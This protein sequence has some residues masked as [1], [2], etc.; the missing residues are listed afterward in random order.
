MKPQCIQAVQAAAA[1][2]GHAKGLSAAQLADI[3][4]RMQR[5]LRHLA[6]T[7]PD[8]QTKP[9]AQRYAEAAAQ[10]MQE[11]KAEAALK[12]QRA[13]MQVVARGATDG[14]IAS[15]LTQYKGLS[16]SEALGRDMSNVDAGISGLRARTMS[17][18]VGLVDAVRNADG[19]SFGRR[20]AMFLWDAENPQ[21]TSDLAREIYASADGST[22]NKI[23]QEGAKAWLQVID[24]MRQRFNAAGGD[25]G[26]L[27]YGYAPIS[28]EFR[29]VR[30]D[31]DLASRDRWVAKTLGL[32]DRGRYVD[33]TG[34]KLGDVAVTDMLNGVWETI[35]S[36]GLNKQ[37]PGQFKG[38]GARA[39]AG[40]EARVLHFK[41]GGA[42]LDYMTSYGR[43]SMYDL[44]M[45]H[46]GKM[47]RDIGLVEAYGP[48]P[49]AQMRTQFDLARQADGGELKKFGFGVGIARIDAQGMW[50]TLSGAASTPASEVGAAFFRHVRNVQSLKLAGTFL[51]MFPDLATYFVTTGFNKLG[52]WNGLANLGR[53]AL[54]ANRDWAAMHGLMADSMARELNRFMGENIGQGWSARL[55]NSQ[56]KLTLGELWT[57]T[58]DRAFGLTKMAALARQAGKDWGSLDQYDRAL[59]ERGGVTA[60]DWRV[61][62]SAQLDSLNGQA[63]LTPDAI[64]AVNHPSAAQVADKI[65]GIVKNQGADAVIKP[66]LEVRTIQTWNGTQAGTA[67]GE[68]ARSVM[69]FK[70]FPIAMVTRHWRQMM[71]AP[72]V[73]DGSAPML[74][75]PW[76]YGGGLAV[77]A[78]ILGAISTQATA[79]ASGKDPIDVTG[80]HA[81]KFW[82]QAFATGGAGGFYADLLTRDSSQDRSAN[83][84]IGKLFG[85]SISD[86][87]TVMQITKGNIDDKLAG[88]QTH[89]AAQG[90]QFAR[91]HVPYLNVWY[92]KAAI[93]HAGMNALQENVSPGYLGRMRENAARQWGEDYW[94]APGTGGPQ[95]APDLGQA[96]GQ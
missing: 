16:R 75:N 64:A 18:L 40:S 61:V 28:H 62:R 83:D 11:V 8:W 89:A 10:A 70:S 90:L 52:Y 9:T 54:K 25:V 43:G 32:L 76:L 78:T 50:R 94:W 93:D 91:S 79:V 29:R 85:P 95:R 72:V 34:A 80:P 86:A 57:D 84:T 56:M 59:L 55:A 51:K 35:K 7:D 6:R 14:R 67:L 38:T 22:G 12:V 71:N 36:D 49:E 65:L 17:R 47:A 41:D 4:T 5:T 37:E 73:T 30:G 46:L 23:A 2:M 3:D 92:L 45:G 60:E 82:L 58:L 31:N 48:N 21:M 39:N 1:A 20:L 13:Q 77:S 19:T 27:D 63:M 88:K 42:Y 15:I 44:M 68:F 69:Q 87:A 74:A 24:E 33:E 53:S 26:R 96:V 81:A 66:D